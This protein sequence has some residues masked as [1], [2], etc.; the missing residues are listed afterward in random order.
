MR[1]YEIVQ[2]FENDRDRLREELQLLR[3][4]VESQELDVQRSH[5][6]FVDTVLYSHLV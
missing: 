3:G 5:K 4:L 2:P 1:V 6:V